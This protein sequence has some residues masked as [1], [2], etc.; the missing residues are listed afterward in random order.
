M[1]M[2]SA[3]PSLR[4]CARLNRIGL[5]TAIA[6]SA[7]THAGCGQ[8]DPAPPGDTTPVEPVGPVDPGPMPYKTLSA[9]RFFTGAMADLTPAAGV[10]PY[11]VS[12]P[13]WS[14]GAGKS[15]FLVLP[16]G[17]RATFSATDDWGF[18]D[19]SILIKSFYFPRDRRDPEGARRLIETRLLIRDDA[20]P[21]GWTAHTYVWNDEQTEATRVIAGR[22]VAVDFIDEAGKPGS[23]LYL[24][25]N[26]NQCGNCHTRDDKYRAIG[27]STAQMN[28]AVER[29][30]APVSQIEWL[31]SEG[32]FDAPLPSPSSALPALPDPFGDAP[33]EARARSYLHANCS[34]CHQPGGGGGSSGLVLLA[35]ETSRTK[36]GVCKGPVAAGSG[37]GAHD[38]DILPGQPDESI[39]PFRMTST[40]P[41]IKMPEIPNLLPHD[42][43]VALIREWIA[44]MVPPGCP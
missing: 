29:D 24:V 26:T 2:L 17:A 36:L 42:E 9:Y 33:V 19:G 3:S 4:A 39:I 30:G 1:K 27:T 28:V 20:E 34:H 38:Y 22:Q 31:A 16:Q 7:A 8:G 32:F 35:T 5:A 40:D 10:V 23:Q 18:P 13:L 37:T 6:L 41:E 14:D 43:G 25:P 15:R 12:S 21:E 11:T 44:A